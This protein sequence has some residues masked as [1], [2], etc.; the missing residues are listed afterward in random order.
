MLELKIDDSVY[1]LEHSLVSI[2]K[3]ESVFKRPFLIEQT[4]SPEEIMF[5]YDC[6]IVEGDTDITQAILRLGASDPDQIVKMTTIMDNYIN[7]DRTATTVSSSGSSN[8]MIF[9]SEVLYAMIAVTGLD[10]SAENWH[11]SR[12]FMAL[13][14][15]ADLKSEKKPMPQSEIIDMQAKLNEERRRKYQSKG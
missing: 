3:W 9:T 12:L 4:F 11:I 10:I 5:Y 2:S 13:A 1:K 7:D 15:I 8:N 6:M 14:V